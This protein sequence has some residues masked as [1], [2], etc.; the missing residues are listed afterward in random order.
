MP[1]E[2][3][4]AESVHEFASFRK[5]IAPRVIRV[6]FWVGAVV[7]FLGGLT[8]M[9][10]DEFFSGLIIMFLGPIAVRVIAEFLLMGFKIYD[11]LVEIRDA[12]K[13]NAP[14]NPPVE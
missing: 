10:K 9:V 5:L 1:C 11:L 12:L 3:L 2:K 13:A 14:A 4:T 6:V 7:V 8:H